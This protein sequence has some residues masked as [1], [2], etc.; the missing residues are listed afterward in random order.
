P[1]LQAR[2]GGVLVRAGHT[3]GSVDLARLAGLKPAAVICEVMTPDGRMAR[4]PDLRE[5]SKHHGLKM[6]TIEELI[7]YRR[8]REKL[9]RRELAIPLPTA[10]GNFDLFAYASVVDPE[11]H[12]ALCM[13][14]V[15]VEVDG[16]VPV[17]DEPV[18]VR[19][20]SE[21]LTGDV[22]DSLR[23]DCGS[24]LHQAME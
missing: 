3:E 17:Q 10:H 2:P 11:P 24:Q 22:F 13:G 12:L 5:F 7:D 15:G 23:C 8:K 18:L 19:V 9:V 21:C 20:H 4:M 6:C 14:G 1:C 16:I